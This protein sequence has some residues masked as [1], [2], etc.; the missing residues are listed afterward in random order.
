[1]NFH[2]GGYLTQS[3]IIEDSGRGRV[4]D[5]TSVQE[6]GAAAYWRRVCAPLFDVSPMR[7]EMSGWDFSAHVWFVGPYVFCRVAS[8][9]SAL[10]RTQRHI[11]TTG[12]FVLALRLS[13]GRILGA[14]A[15]VPFDV[16]AG[17][18]AIHDYASE[19]EAV[20][21]PSVLEAVFVPR[22]SGYGRTVMD[23]PLTVLAQDGVAHQKLAGDFDRVFSRLRRGAHSIPVSALGSLANPV[24]SLEPGQG[25]VVDDRAAMRDANHKQ[26]ITYIEQRLASKSLAASEIINAFGVSRATL[27]R[28]FEEAG[29]VRTYICDRRVFRA[30]YEIASSPH[31]RGLI[32]RASDR[33]GFT[34][35]TH[36]NRAVHR[37][38][39]SAPGGL[40]QVPFRERRS[41]ALR[42]TFSAEML[43]RGLIRSA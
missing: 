30:L 27:Y 43:E 28:L 32:Q 22:P 14:A 13:K 34:S 3:Q 18:I 39:D 37:L 40:F 19:F 23:S 16:Q 41:A 12:R 11:S 15:G 9:G 6:Q 31:N 33:W 1:L 26:I 36:F 4:L 38:L 24:S 8:G 25:G 5:V 35:G 17:N 29:G 21:F 7:D 2:L 42:S 20:Q 10:R